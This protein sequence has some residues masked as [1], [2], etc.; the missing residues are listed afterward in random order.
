ME[1]IYEFLVRHN[2][3]AEAI[4]PNGLKGEEEASNEAV[5]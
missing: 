4:K 5:L 2:R 3:R 1:Q